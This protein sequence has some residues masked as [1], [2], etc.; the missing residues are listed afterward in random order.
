MNIIELIGF[1]T[2]F[3]LIPAAVGL[4][5]CRKW[6]TRD[7]PYWE[8]VNFAIFLMPI[9]NFCGLILIALNIVSYLLKKSDAYNSI[10]SYFNGND[11]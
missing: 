4:F 9:F 10:K 5:L 7:I 2:L 3:Y 8:K 11:I 6:N 1:F